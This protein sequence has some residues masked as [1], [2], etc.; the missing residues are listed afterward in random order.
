MLAS[1]SNLNILCY[2]SQGAGY[3]GYLSKH[4]RTC[5]CQR[6]KHFTYIFNKHT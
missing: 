3:Q 4:F 5:V 2:L 1:R 6:Y